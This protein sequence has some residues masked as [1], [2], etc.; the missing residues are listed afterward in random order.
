ME[1]GN[2]RI[3]A[4]GPTLAPAERRKRAIPHCWRSLRELGGRACGRLRVLAR[5][6]K[7]RRFAYLS[8]RSRAS[9]LALFAIV[10][11][12]AL[13]PASARADQVIYG[14]V[15]YTWEGVQYSQY[16]IVSPSKY[17][18]A[19]LSLGLDASEFDN[20][21]KAKLSNESTGG[22]FYTYAQNFENPDPSGYSLTSLGV[23]PG[24]WATAYGIYGEGNVWYAEV[25]EPERIAA[26]VD[27]RIVKSGGDIGGGGSGSGNVD[28]DYLIYDHFLGNAFPD[29]QT[30]KWPKAGLDLTDEQ[31]EGLSGSV[32]R[33]DSI[34]TSTNKV[35]FG[36]IVF[37]KDGSYEIRNDSLFVTGGSYYYFTTNTWSF[38]ID[39]SVMTIQPDRVLPVNASWTHITS[40]RELFG[41]N[42]NTRSFFE[43]G[44]PAPVVPPTNW[45]EPDPPTTP[46][47]PEVDP[48]TNPD[49]PNVPTTPTPPTYPPQV[50]YPDVTYVEAD[51]SAV[52]DALNE[53]CEHLQDS[54]Y[55]NSVNL[56]NSL[57]GSIS[58]EF[59]S[60]K[61]FL[62]AL[63]S[64]NVDAINENFDALYTYF[65][66]FAVWLDSR[67]RSDDIVDV[68]MRIYGL[69]PD[70]VDLSTVES[71]L[72][73]IV[74][75]V[76]LIV[77]ALNN[78]QDDSGLETVR[79]YLKG[80]Y[81]WLY[82]LDLSGVGSDLSV[83]EHQLTDLTESDNVTLTVRGLLHWIN[84]YA[85][86]VD[87]TIHDV[88][89]ELSS[90]TSDCALFWSDVKAY[91]DDILD[92][93]D[94]LEITPRVRYTPTN[95]PEIPDA[96]DLD[97]DLNV[98]ALRDALSRLMEKFPFST[99]NN[100]VLILTLLTRPAQA[101]VFDLPLP[102]PSDWSSPYMVNVDLSIWDVPAAVLRTG[103]V[104][105]AIARVSRRTVSMWTREEGGGQ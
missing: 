54:I 33:I 46:D 89:D 14:P 52:L 43:L 16:G 44:S 66:D 20:T 93:L 77:Q 49:P 6:E 68:L 37:V 91:L 42:V 62:R 88:Y 98:D 47:P 26:G 78:L 57:Q 79:G 53:H 102:N 31:I 73:D 29:V 41:V 69:M 48:P 3:K 34:D 61:T 50:T 80:M 8:G 75:D 35:R 13:F 39:G 4:S 76:E 12:F 21:A 95:P 17:D 24:F 101:P 65:T 92:A 72:A 56:Y 51:L 84:H 60:L 38:V 74:A 96:P 71:D 100:F 97:A 28:G 87:R 103:I 11:S 105:W 90:F 32:L 18:A 22:A 94:N 30:I 9:V 27:A 58:G 55:Q 70:S 99:I 2:A 85:A 1:V 45:P 36:G 15:N 7:A 59:T 10:A 86:E 81:D 82:D 25:S 23:V 40:D 67:M 83:L 63:A 5:P 64:W 104:I 19:L